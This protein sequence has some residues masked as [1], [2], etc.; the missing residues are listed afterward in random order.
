MNVEI[1]V[2]SSPV[3]SNPIRPESPNQT[4]PNP[5]NVLTTKPLHRT[6]PVSFLSYHPRVLPHASKG[7]GGR[8]RRK[9]LN[10]TTSNYLSLAFT[11]SHSFFGGGIRDV[12]HV[13]R[14]KVQSVPLCPCPS[15][16][17]RN[18]TGA[19]GRPT[20]RPT[21]WSAPPNCVF[22]DRHRHIPCIFSFFEHFV[23]VFGRSHVTINI[24][25][26]RTIFPLLSLAPLF[27]SLH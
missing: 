10:T 15:L 13:S 22:G 6:F 8:E 2:Q 25:D 3:Q 24:R 5:A 9:E 21:S 4:K 26:R 11:S 23:F 19:L 7:G 16:V 27:F 12:Q 18:E 1:P 20:K 14:G 17:L